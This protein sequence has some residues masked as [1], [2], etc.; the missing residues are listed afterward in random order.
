MREMTTSAFVLL[1]SCVLLPV[2]VSAQTTTPTYR[3]D[4][5]PATVGVKPTEPA[6]TDPKAPITVLPSKMSRWLELQTGTLATRY[7]YVE[8]SSGVVSANQM[9][10]TGQLKSRVKLDEKGRFTVNALFAS[11]TAFTGGWNTTGVGTGDL[12]KAWPLK[13][14]F[15][16][17]VPTTGV[18]LSFGSIG[19]TRGES[20]EIT[21]Y[22]NDGYVTGERASVKRP[23]SLYFDELGV[24]SAFLGHTSVPAFWDRANMM[25][26]RNYFQYFAS[27]KVSPTFAASAD[28]TRYLGVATFR[29][30]GVV[31]APKA[32]VFDSVRYEQ[33]FRGGS[34]PGNGFAVTID[35]A[36]TKKFSVGAGFANIDA[37]NGTLNADR[38]AKG[39]RFFQT[40]TVK[41]TPELAFQLFLTES[42]HN[43]YVVSN[44]FRYEVIASYNVLGR[45]QRAGHLK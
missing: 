39:N 13:Q 4:G 32:R 24:T 31:K 44:R 3:S 25:R 6:A 40:T 7:R 2:V 18:E 20:T 38:F 12:I 36:V 29:M 33:Y 21:S 27:K 42:V 10:Y 23:K 14:I 45:I 30:A 28:Y 34:T 26:T 19:F 43:P 5:T 35:K 11:G 1:M 9:Q 16:T 8:S 41:V 15:A 22:D 37:N 17:A